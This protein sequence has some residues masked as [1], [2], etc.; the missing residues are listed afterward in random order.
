MTE[1]D[2]HK[3]QADIL[4]RLSAVDVA[5][6]AV[7]KATVA[8]TLEQYLATLKLSP[9]PIIWAKDAQHAHQ[10]VVQSDLAFVEGEL[11][12]SL[13]DVFHH[14]MEREHQ[15]WDEPRARAREAGHG[16]QLAVVKALVQGNSVLLSIPW[17]AY[18]GRSTGDRGARTSS[19]H[20]PPWGIVSDALD[21]AARASA[22]C[23]WARVDRSHN[24]GGYVNHVDKWLPFIDAFA[25]GL[26]CF[27]ITDSDVIALPRPTLELNVHD[28]LHSERGPAVHWDDGE[29]VF[30]FLNGVHVP[31]EIVETPASELDP[32]LLLRERN[33]EVRRELVRKIG[34]ERVCEVLEAK[35][36]DRQGNYELLLLDLQDGR[37]RPFLKMK[38]P[39]I[40]VYHIE[41]VAPECSTVAEALAWRNQS[42]VPPSV[43]T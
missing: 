1:M 32:R 20:D 37:T 33:V 31:R 8:R 22:E 30:F 23:V 12:D 10:M 28:Q 24:S 29:Q 21:Y 11:R 25:A 6:G 9:R 36:L 13:V 42:D 4:S 40:G 19:S 26:W 14:T 43:L 2:F 35:C 41:G 17:R 34:I 3:L 15:L 27:W 7:D 16:T 39:S 5:S 38:N 18:E